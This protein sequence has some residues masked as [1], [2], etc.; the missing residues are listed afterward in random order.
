MDV[1]AGALL[2]NHW[3][4]GDVKDSELCTSTGELPAPDL[5]L[6]STL[7]PEGEIITI[8]CMAP[9]EVVVTRIFFCKDG[10]PI[11]FKKATSQT[12]QYI[13]YASLKNTGQYSCGY[14]QNNAKNQVKTSALSVARNLVFHSGNCPSNGELPAPDLLLN[15]TLVPEGET[16]TALCAAPAEVVVTGFFF[17]KDGALVSFKKAICQITQYIVY[18]SPKNAGHY[19]CG[20]QQKDSKNQVKTSALSVAQNL[21]VQSG[22]TISPYIWI[23]RSSLVLLLLVSAPIITYFME[24]CNCSLVRHRN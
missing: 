14:Q 4:L 21:I 17:C 15:T 8:L 18:A 11:S 1:I 23:L 20:Y 16:I 19:S 6:N 10:V 22:Q 7:V 9:S 12:A 5:F 2:V 13:V 3:C 24:K